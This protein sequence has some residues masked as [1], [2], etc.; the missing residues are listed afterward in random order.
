MTEPID[1]LERAKGSVNAGFPNRS[2]AEALIAIA[3]E[4]RKMNERAEREAIREAG[5]LG[6]TILSAPQS[7]PAPTNPRGTTWPP[8]NTPGT[9]W[10]SDC[11]SDPKP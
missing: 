2:Q 11:V 1:W 9:T 6:V 7:I 4:L 10:Q 3:E 8:V 5:Q